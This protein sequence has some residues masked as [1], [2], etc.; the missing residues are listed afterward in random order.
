MSS[1]FALFYGDGS[2]VKD[3]GQ[4]VEI[5]FR[6]PRAWIDSPKDGVQFVVAPGL[7]GKLVVYEQKDLYFMLPG[8]E[9]MATDDLGPVLRSLG[10]LKCGLWI[11]NEEYAAI[12]ETVRAY[13]REHEKKNKTAR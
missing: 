2:I 3:D 11:P 9:P 10:L 4:D 6:V 13:R 12:R 8:G 5:T 7:D 1:R